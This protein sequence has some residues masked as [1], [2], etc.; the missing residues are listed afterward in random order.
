[1]AA[2]KLSFQFLFL[3]LIAFFIAALTY[4]GNIIQENKYMLPFFASMA[5]ADEEEDEDRDE[6]DDEKKGSSIQKKQS[7]TTKTIQVIE[8]RKVSK[9][10]TVTPE[11]YARD[12]D[13]DGLVDALDPNP[14]I[15]QHEY[16]TDDD[17]DG[18]PNVLDLYP[19]KD[20]FTFFDGIE[21][22]TNGDGILDLY[23]R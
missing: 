11:E 21:A 15:D 23:Q 18:V 14:L 5:F 9:E 12:S 17:S 10:V 16:F 7:K 4:S 19:G 20:D 3:T 22:D 1:M 13:G 8:Y 2:I 6:S